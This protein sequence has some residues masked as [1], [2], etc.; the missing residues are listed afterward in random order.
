ARPVALNN[1]FVLAITTRLA[2]SPKAGQRDD[3]FPIRGVLKVV[4]PT[5]DP[6]AGPIIR[7][8]ENRHVPRDLPMLLHIRLDSLRGVVHDQ[9]GLASPRR[10]HA[11]MKYRRLHHT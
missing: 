5:I 7:S 9:A 11:R 4:A 2:V 1:V 6:A 10:R 3:A 8:R